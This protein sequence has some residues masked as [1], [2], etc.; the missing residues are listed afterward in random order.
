LQLHYIIKCASFSPCHT[1]WLLDTSSALAAA[2][3]AHQQL[4]VALQAAEPMRNPRASLLTASCMRALQGAEPMGNLRARLLTASCRQVLAL[5]VKMPGSN[6]WS[7]HVLLEALFRGTRLAAERQLAIYWY[8]NICPALG[9]DTAGQAEGAAGLAAAGFDVSVKQTLEALENSSKLTR[10]MPD[11]V[12]LAEQALLNS[13]C[14][15][16]SA[17]PSL[18]IALTV[19]MS[20]SVADAVYAAAT[21]AASQQGHT[22]AQRHACAKPSAVDAQPPAADQ[23]AQRPSGSAPGRTDR[24]R[25]GIARA[26]TGL[27][28]ASA[29]PAHA[30]CHAGVPAPPP[31]VHLTSSQ[32]KPCPLGHKPQAS[33]PL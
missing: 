12:R 19:A 29:V 16:G 8:C 5:L 27:E 24:Q 28:A 11:C 33:C 22:L 2:N 25:S 10:N 18:N 6:E 13:H 9:A 26:F 20:S 23:P 17:L 7:S 4:T 32:A 1:G 3:V 15:D 31:G 21:S 30:S 14:P